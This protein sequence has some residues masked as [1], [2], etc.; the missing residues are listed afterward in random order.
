MFVFDQTLQAIWYT[1][2]TL[3]HRGMERV[4]N[5]IDVWMSTF[6]PRFLPGA[7]GEFCV[8]DEAEGH[9][10]HQVP[11]GYVTTTAVIGAE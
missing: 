8:L 7:Y 9:R 3:P 4:F 1:V 6:E 2:H 10:R 11:I 5:H